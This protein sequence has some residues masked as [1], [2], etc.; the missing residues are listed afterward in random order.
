METGCEHTVSQSLVLITNKSVKWCKCNLHY[1]L[2]GARYEVYERG[3][4]RQE[5]RVYSFSTDIEEC[6]TET[7]NC[8][9]D[10]NCT[11]TKGSFYCTCHTG[12]S[13]D[14]VTCVGT[15]HST[16]FFG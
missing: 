5:I 8:H 9:N 14:G 12:Y 4:R 3:D 6:Q 10:A 16:L 13:G 1:E 2:A 7:D 11:N 15:W